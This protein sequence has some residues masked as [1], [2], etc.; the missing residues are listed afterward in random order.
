MTANERR[1]KI[2]EIVNKTES[3]KSSDLAEQLDVTT[4]TIRKDL[5]Y[6]NK[7]KL[8]QKFHG[9][10]KPITE[11]SEHS[12]DFRLGEAQSSKIVIAQAA[13]QQLTDCTVIFIDAGS[14]AYEFAKYLKSHIDADNSLD[15]LV[16][17]T[18]SFSAVQALKDIPN[19]IYFIGGEINMT[20]QSTNGFWSSNELHSLHI[21][22]AFLGSSGFSSHSGPCTKIGSDTLIK[23]EIIQASDKIVVLADHS[24]FTSNSIMQYALWSNIDLLITDSQVDEES[25]EHLRSQVDII[26]A[27]IK[28]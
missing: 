6:L 16:I 28:A 1:E 20:T 21:D 7:K 2:I 27:P 11:T 25:I 3:I 5:I 24:K 19:T 22:I 8:I 10:A 9:Y 26:V 4:E 12:L 18:N 23:N 17:V 13:F 15:K 14:T